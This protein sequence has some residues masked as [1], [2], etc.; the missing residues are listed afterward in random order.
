MLNILYKLGVSRK[1]FTQ[2]IEKMSSSQKK[3]VELAKSLLTLAHVFL[4]DEPLNY[5]DVFNQKQIEDLI[6]EEK[7]AMVI[8]EHDQTFLDNIGA[9]QVALNSL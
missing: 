8:I 5:L 4:W 9:K 7:P 3:R 1:V 2:S 6:L